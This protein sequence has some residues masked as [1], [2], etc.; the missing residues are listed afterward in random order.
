MIGVDRADEFG[1]LCVPFGDGIRVALTR[2]GQSR[3]AAGVIGQLPSN[4]AWLIDI[5]RN[6]KLYILVEFSSDSHVRVKFV[7][8]LRY[9][10]LFDVKIHTT[11]EISGKQQ[12]RT[13]EGG[14][15]T[16]RSH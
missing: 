6:H 13:I 9:A 14:L 4:D 8:R 3:V 12:V 2:S 11:Y 10:E 5:A 16:D 7:M 1:C 15:D